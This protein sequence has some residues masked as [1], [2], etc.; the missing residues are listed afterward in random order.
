MQCII[1]LKSGTPGILM[2]IWVSNVKNEIRI[3]LEEKKR[4]V[5]SYGPKNQGYFCLQMH[6]HPGVPVVSVSLFLSHPSAPNISAFL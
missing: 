4:S 2:Y 1:F 6:L 3:Y 5:S